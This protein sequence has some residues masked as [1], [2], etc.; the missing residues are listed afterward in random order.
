MRPTIT[1]WRL[2]TRLLTDPGPAW[3]VAIVDD[4][5]EVNSFAVDLGLGRLVLVESVDFF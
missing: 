1:V 5:T 4:A 3:V 2:G